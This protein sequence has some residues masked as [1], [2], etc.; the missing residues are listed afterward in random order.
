MPCWDV[1]GL[2]PFA[3]VRS[4]VI[5]TLAAEFALVVVAVALIVGP[6][7]RIGSVTNESGALKVPFA[8]LVLLIVESLASPL[9]VRVVACTSLVVLVP[10]P[11]ADSSSAAHGE[12]AS[13]H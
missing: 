13:A 3:P 8:R 9:S 10:G 7:E 5:C 6:T 1:I 4:E 11:F 12:I 2:S